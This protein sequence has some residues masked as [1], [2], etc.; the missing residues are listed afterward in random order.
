MGTITASRSYVTGV[1]SAHAP[2]GGY[3]QS[4][5]DRERG[6]EGIRAFQDLKHLA[7]GELR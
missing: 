7:I 2:G 5:L 1:F 4:G 6:L 3:K